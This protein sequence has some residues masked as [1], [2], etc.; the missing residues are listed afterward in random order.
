ME[1]AID[2]ARWVV[3]KALSPLSGGLLETWAASSEL[4]VNIDAIKME[5]LYAKGMLENAQG[6][7]I[8]SQAL[9]ELLQKLQQLAFDADDVLDELDYFRIHDELKG[10]YEAA[11][12][13]DAS[14]FRGI[15]VNSRHTAK[16][17]GKSL[18]CFHSDA[19]HG[20]PDNPR[21]E[22]RQRV[23]MLSKCLPC[24]SCPPVHENTA[25]D[26]VKSQKWWQ[27]HC[28]ACCCSP[29]PGRDRAN[30]APM[31]KFDRVGISTRMKHIT[32]Q[33]QP[34]CAKVSVILN[35]EMLGSKSNTQD[36][37]TSQRIT[38]SKSVEPK[39]YGR[40]KMK[41]EIIRDVTKGIYSEQ[42]LS[43]LSLFGPG[44]IGKTTLVQYIYNNQELQSHFQVK[45][46][47]CV[48]F[49][50]NV[51]MLLQQIMDQIPKVD[52]ENGTA[53]DRIEQRLKSKRFLLILDD[54]W[55][56]DG[57][58]MW[59]RL[60]VPFR[61]SQ[62]KGNAVVVTTRFPALAE[63]VNTMDHPIELER[64]EQE[65]FMQLFEACVFGEAKAPWQDHSELLDVGKKII[66]KLKGFPLA[67]KTVGRLLRNNLTLDHWRRVL[68]S[69]EWELQTGHNDIMPALKLSYVYLP[70]HLQKCFSY[71]GLFPHDY[72]FDSGEL[73]HLWM[74]LNIL[75]CNGQKTFEEIGLNYLDDLVDHGFMKK[76]EKDG[77]P[78][79]VMH[80]LLQD[81]ARMVSSYECY[82]IDCS[83]ERFRE[84]PPDVR[85]LSIVM[86]G[87]EED[88]SINETFHGNVILIMKRFK[89]ENLHTLMIFGCYYRSMANTFGDVFRKAKALRVLRLSTMYYPVDHILHNFS[90]LMHLRYLK[91]GSE[92]DKISPPRCISRFYKL[93]VLD[94]KDWKGSINLPVDMSNL[95]RLRHFIVSHDETH[96]KICEVGKLQTL[97]ELR[98]F[99]VNREKSGFEIKQ[100]AHLIQLSGSLSICNLEKM[101]AKEADEVNLLS[102]NSLKK[103]TLEWDVQRSQKEPDKEQHI[104]NVLRPHD[105]L[106]ELCIRG[107]GGHSCPPWLGSKLS[108]KNLQSLHL[109]TVN[110]TVFPPLGEFWLPKEPGQEYLRSVQGKSFQ[111]LKTLEL[112]GL[113]RLEKWVHNDKFL[114]F[115]LLEI[116]IIRDCPE[117]VELP[118]SQY[119]SQKFKQDVMID[120]FPKMQEVRIADC[121]KLESLPLIPWTDTLHTVDMKNV[122][123][124]LEK[125][126]YSTKSSS[127][128]LLLEIKEDHHLEYLDEM[129]AFHNLSKI[130]ELEVS[131]SPP[132]MN[133]HLHWLTSLKTLKI[134]DSSITLPLLGG[135]DDE[136]DTLALERLEIKNCSANGKELT[137]FLLQLP[138]LS[139]FRMSSCQNVTS[140]GVMALLATA[141]PTS[142]PSSSTS[143]NETGSQLQIEEVGDEGGLL[144]F[145]KHLTISLRELRITMNPGLSLLASLPPENNSRPGG[146]HN[147]HS[148]QT[149][150]IR[151]CPKLLSAYSSS[152]SYC[153][154]FPSTLD[155]LRIEDVEDMHTF[156][157]L[158][159]LTSLTYLF[160]E[161][162]GKDL[163]GEGLWTFFTQGC[164]TRLC[165][166]RSPNFFD[167]LVPH[168]QEELPAY[169]KIE[170][171][172]TDDIAGVL[173][174]PICRLFSSSLNVL[175]LCS[176]KEIVSFTK[177][178]EK[179]LELITSLQDLCFFHN[180]KLQS[181]PADLR[182]LN[183]L[184]ILE[185]LRCSAIRSLPKNAFPNSLQKIN[186]D[187]RCSEELQHHCIMLEG[188]TVNID[189]PVNTNL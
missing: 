188:V 30:E 74:G 119:A 135:P 149:L 83:H 128:K 5:L 67:A 15:L 80:D 146:L 82:T 65:E 125:L 4:G 139:F 58:D 17:V 173:V 141:E 129:V 35:M 159:N 148:L 179:A 68:A 120:L 169:C 66:G 101:Q 53:E 2:A 123:S 95:A 156:T 182:G 131:K 96:S 26:A 154:P 38:I 36:S 85:H 121:P 91:L 23:H 71:C 93:I 44:G 138:K 87:A 175:G 181:L 56:C 94:L 3:D 10:T 81:L 12:V 33:L 170:M 47:V 177:E 34:I 158:S 97:Q 132:L 29:N 59:K 62:A 133:K 164:L 37:T 142:M 114:L 73:I 46:W 127:S 57:E 64:L 39:L 79:Y 24:Y 69:K 172:R 16:A 113:T 86:G 161:N 9:K 168:Q 151:G 185:I 104:L 152:S 166:Y 174:T 183:N 51:S 63:M 41:D 100:L 70:F 153:F 40:N 49:S 155:S 178:Q 22:A 55:K 145:P 89:V 72:E 109:D 117:L 50:F 75:C 32:E 189:R 184:R 186:V 171:L 8:R 105:N 48:S 77:H 180:E 107:H 27:K 21:T 54:M 14:C 162:C 144:L 118:V 13:D 43:V 157:P 6:R 31:H 61:K 111:N 42:D 136:K 108:V 11:D 98:R 112:V 165:V 103:L 52:G 25:D 143:S 92:Y 28:G 7:E 134:S 76:D 99:E 147:L 124:S 126:V 110:W 130:H 137:Q 176:N 45:I 1:V 78:I 20:D 19:Y 90:V 116:F 60:L 163:R 106:Q 167:N 84:I 160:V 140:M 18:S 102:K 122:G 115:S 187:R 88:A 150:F